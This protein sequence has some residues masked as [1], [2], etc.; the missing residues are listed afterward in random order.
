MNKS[1]S[2]SVEEVDTQK[3]HQYINIYTNIIYYNFIELANRTDVVHTKEDIHKLLLSCDMHGYVVRF[4]TKI[5]GYLFGEFIT[6]SDGRNVYYLSYIYI[7]PKY[8]QYKIGSV[9]LQKIIDK[10]NNRGVMF[11]V[12][13]CDTHDARV[14]HFY[15]KFGFIPDP[16]LKRNVSIQDGFLSITSLNNMMTPT[17]DSNNIQHDVLCLYL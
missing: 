3:I 2:L 17:N 9:L 12:L 6:L 16:V 14:M 13:T 4:T 8:R 1:N 5:V 15:K 10:C 7:A 11:I